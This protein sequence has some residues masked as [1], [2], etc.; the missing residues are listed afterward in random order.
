[1]AGNTLWN[2]VL[3]ALDYRFPEVKKGKGR[4]SQGKYREKIRDGKASHQFETA[5]QV[6][7][8]Q[9]ATMDLERD[10]L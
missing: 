2:G 7:T 10:P 9:C 1:M 6:D 5:Y 4:S 8:C 3:M